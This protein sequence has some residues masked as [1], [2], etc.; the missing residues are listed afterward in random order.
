MKCRNCGAEEF[1][2]MVCAYCGTKEMVKD[3]KTNEEQGN[4]PIAMFFDDGDYFAYDV[5]TGA[6][7]DDC[8]DY[9]ECIKQITKEIKFLFEGEQTP[10]EEDIN[11]DN[12]VKKLKS[13]CNLKIV[14]IK[15]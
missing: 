13:K 3:K 9:D 12:Y 1:N 2:N 5:A 6:E 10:T 15:I 14:Y 4:W 8:Q 7:T 11:N